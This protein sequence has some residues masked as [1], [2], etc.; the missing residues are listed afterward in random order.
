M[1]GLRPGLWGKTVGE[2]SFFTSKRSVLRLNVLKYSAVFDEQCFVLY[3]FFEG[4]R[5]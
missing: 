2:L 5:K 4:D 1:V 3:D